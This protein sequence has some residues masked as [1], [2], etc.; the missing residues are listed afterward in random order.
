[1]VSA[2][3]SGDLSSETKVDAFRRLFPLSY[4]ERS[5]LDSICL[6]ARP[7]GRARDTSVALGL[8]KLA[9][10]MKNMHFSSS[11][12]VIYQDLFFA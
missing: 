6:D 10:A 4:H 5:L 8:L 3:V 11:Y 7:L 12:F 1:M 9:L 2:N